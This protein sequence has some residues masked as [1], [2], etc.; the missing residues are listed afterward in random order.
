MAQTSISINVK[1]ITWKINAIKLFAS[2]INA[3]PDLFN[4]KGELNLTVEIKAKKL[5]DYINKPIP[6]A[7]KTWKR[8]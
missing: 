5:V 4:K 1:S 2:L 6:K 8:T 3:L 7:I